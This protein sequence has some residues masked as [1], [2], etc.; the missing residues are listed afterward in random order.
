MTNSDAA[1]P[2]GG[3]A[4]PTLLALIDNLGEGIMRVFAA[5]KGL[6]V[7]VG[8]I[9]IHDPADIARAEPGDVILGV[10]VN[11]DRRDAIDL[12]EHAGVGGAA[13]V[14]VKC[15]TD[16]SPALLDAANQAGVA[17]LGAVHEVGWGQ[18]HSLLR[19]ARSTGGPQLGP[20]SAA[21]GDLFA[22]ANAVA[23]MAG[24]PTTIEDTQSTV[25]AYSSSD[26]PIDDARR[27]TILGRRVPDEW[28][29]RLRADGVFRRLWASDDVVRIDYPD[30]PDL[31]TRLAIAVRAGSEI[32][33]SIWVL[34]GPR[35][36]GPG[37]EAGLRDAARIAALHLIRHQSS[38]DLERRRRAEALRAAIDG[39]LPPELLSESI[40]L[41]AG[42]VT[43]VAFELLD[44]EGAELALQAER[45][46]NLIALYGE[47]YR[48]AAACVAHGRVI[49]VLV[50]TRGDSPR[51]EL[52]RLATDMV[53]RAEAALRVRMRAGVGTTIA[54]LHDLPEGRAA[55]DNVLQAL[56][57]RDDRRQVAHIDDVRPDVVLLEL[58]R[59][60][61]HLVEGKV[62]LMIEHDH[63]HQT[64]Y[65]ETLKAYLDAF[66]DVG[67]AA[68]NVKVHANTLRYRLRR[69]VELF[70]FDL[71]DPV[72]RLVAHLQLFLA[73]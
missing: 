9:V 49:Y 15:G 72:E 40:E 11:A 13:A 36:F 66:G 2:S 17:V 55:A 73:E 63:A 48:R 39:R 57:D 4:V 32:L 52:V 19:T 46:V 35:G 31:R 33:G 1:A 43:V 7:A 38:E 24:G 50:P 23:A 65:A 25:L 45:A 42:P 47:A 8:D 51:D 16:A 71:D 3:R 34:E 21:S 56:A 64:A 26:D 37:A 60:A 61:E 67:R 41:G 10:G 69:L 20:H 68:E 44:V 22:L 18:L 70:G 29:A 62:Q 30:I 28:I 14:V 59:R 27:E 53:E 6:D 5:P 54:S 12:V 58:K